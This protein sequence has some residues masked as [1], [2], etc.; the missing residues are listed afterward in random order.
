MDIAV[1]EQRSTAQKVLL[2][3]C[4]IVGATGQAS[5]ERLFLLFAARY[6]VEAM[7]FL[8][9]TWGCGPKWQDVRFSCAAAHPFAWDAQVF[10]AFN[11]PA[12]VVD[13]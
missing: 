10:A 5:K 9:E 12:S 8:K 7:P 1:D 3:H 4:G 13:M 11:L 6:D 2:L